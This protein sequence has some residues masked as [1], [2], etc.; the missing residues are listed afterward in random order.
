MIS[1]RASAPLSIAPAD[2]P[3]KAIVLMVAA[4]FVFSGVDG[5]SKALTADYHPVLVSWGRFLFQTLLLVPVVLYMGALRVLRT[6]AP[7][8]QTLR[9]V[10]MYGSSI[11]FISGLARLPLAEAASIGFA[12]PLFTTALSIPLLGEKVGVRR[13]SALLVG[14]AGVLI[15]IRPG[16]A[17]FDWASVLPLLSAAAWSLG[18]IVTRRMNT[19]ADLPVTTLAYASWVGLVA[20]SLPMPWFW[21][22]PTPG[23]WAAMLAMAALSCAGHYLLILAFRIGPASILAPFSY[24]QM[25]WATLIG[26]FAFAALP[27]QWTW[28]GAAV[29]MASGGYTWHRE[30][31]RHGLLRQ[32]AEE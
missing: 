8:Q 9:A 21:T 10:C 13:W 31:V 30:R 24:S 17:A 23:A 11:F 27:D 19:L 26:Y 5:V 7:W 3:L 18:L 28:V 15:V 6:A 32:R 22:Q 2:E 4:M 1:P 20:A 16:T 29:I 12:A 25:I 14:F